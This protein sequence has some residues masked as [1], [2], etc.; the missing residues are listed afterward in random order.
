MNSYTT[1]THFLFFKVN[2]MFGA[3][4]VGKILITALALIAV[5]YVLPGVLVE[6]FYVALIVA[7]VMGFLNL[8]LKPILVVLTLPVTIMTLGLFMWVING[9]IF[10]VVA[11]FIDGF[12]VENFWWAILGA[13]IVSAFAW[14]GEKLLINE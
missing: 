14:F 13:L 4:A 6:T 3:K 12:S 5:A 1:F 10:W 8:I 2:I 7:I 9:F 11:R